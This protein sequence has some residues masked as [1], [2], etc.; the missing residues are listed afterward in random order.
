MLVTVLLYPPSVRCL[1][2]VMGVMAAATYA[3]IARLPTQNRREKVKVK[4]GA[5]A[6]M[7]AKAIGAKAKER[8]IGARA[9]EKARDRVAK[10]KGMEAIGAK[11]RA[12]ACMG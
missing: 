10:A 4:G 2:S 1:Q 12:K 6:K 8:A 7:E 5:A 9:E 3:M 11:A